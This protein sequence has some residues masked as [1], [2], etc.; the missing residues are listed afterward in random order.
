[1]NGQHDPKG[2]MSFL[3][4][5]LEVAAVIAVVV[6]FAAIVARN[7]PAGGPESLLNVSY[8]PTR[9]LYQALNQQF[10]AEYARRTG[11]HLTIIQSHGGSTGQARAVIS[12]AAPADVVT[13]GLYS[14]IDALRKRHLIADGWADRLPHHSQPYTSTVVFVVR[15]GNPRHIHDWPDLLQTGVEIITPDPKTS[16]NGK[17]SALAA[18]GA[19]VLRGGTEQQARQYLQQF[20][21]HVPV[22]DAG[23]RSAATTF[24]VQEVGDVHL[25]WENE[26]VREVAD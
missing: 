23:A 2:L 26:A 17:L 4:R 1:M 3:H 20:Y 24:A 9:E 10:V 8:D 13:L 22:L 19:I 6:A 18:W 7:Y 12:G 15:A 16:G 25:T 14:D 11:R 21:E 5:R